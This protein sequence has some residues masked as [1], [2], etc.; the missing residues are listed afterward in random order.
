MQVSIMQFF[1]CFLATFELFWGGPRSFLKIFENFW[2]IFKIFEKF[3]KTFQNF[4]KFFEIKK[5]FLKIFAI[6]KI[7]LKILA[8][9]EPFLGG[10]R[11]FLSM[12]LSTRYYSAGSPVI[13]DNAT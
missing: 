5:K 12:Q 6:F 11:S 7:F 8:I 10:P 9:F 1:G 4:L 3:L 13:F 2:K